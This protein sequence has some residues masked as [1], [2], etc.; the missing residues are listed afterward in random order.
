MQN[1]K[2]SRTLKIA[3]KV[4]LLLMLIAFVLMFGCTE[5]NPENSNGQDLGDRG[6][7]NGPPDGQIRNGIGNRSFGGRGIR[8]SSFGN[9]T[10][11]ERRQLILQ[12][13][14]PALEA[15]YNKNIQDGCEL[16]DPRGETQ[17]GICVTNNGKIECEAGFNTNQKLPSPT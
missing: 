6:N 8:N 11:E 4:F 9:L 16:V 10:D 15:C 1:E 5:N 7:F 13:R 14:Q 12:R 3:I 2:Q 17:K